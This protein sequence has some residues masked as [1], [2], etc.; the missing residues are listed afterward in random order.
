[1]NCFKHVLLLFA[2]FLVME[3]AF[4]QPDKWGLP[5]SPNGTL[6][7]ALLDAVNESDASAHRIFIESNFTSDFQNAMPMENHLQQ[8]Q[9]MHEDLAGGQVNGVD[10]RM[11]PDGA[12]TLMVVL[13]TPEDEYWN[14]SLDVQSADSPKIAGMSVELSPDGPP[15]VERVIRTL[16][17]TINDSD[18]ETHRTFIETYFSPAF[19][20]EFTM[21]AHLQQFQQLHQDLAG[22]NPLSVEAMSQ[23]GTDETISMLL[24]TDSGSRFKLEFDV[25][26]TST[27]PRLISLSV[28]PE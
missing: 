6:I 17:A 28:Q 25:Q 23:G 3:S 19:K 12:R 7:A 18:P 22:A 21:D 8:F 16:M 9:Q 2:G 27:P 24:E 4:A 5:D 13:V 26:T 1:M 15:P 20:D 10:M 14:L 11:M